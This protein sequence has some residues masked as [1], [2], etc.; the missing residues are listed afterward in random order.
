[1]LDGT[2]YVG[3]FKDGKMWGIGTYTTSQGAV[4]TGAFDQN[5]RRGF[6]KETFKNYVYEGQWDG[7]KHGE[8][9]MTFPSGMVY[10][11]EFKDGHINGYG[12]ETSPD[13]SS[14]EGYWKHEEPHGRGIEIDADGTKHIGTWVNGEMVKTRTEEEIPE[15]KSDL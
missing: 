1:M 15:L 13:G 2:V 11:G 8:G 14:H 12:K 9:K 6:G 5:I 4:Y 3:D 10:V 7:V